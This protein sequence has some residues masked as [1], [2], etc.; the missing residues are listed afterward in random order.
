V[1]GIHF[2]S[3]GSVGRLKDR[4]WRA[5]YVLL[6]AGDGQVHTEVIRVGYDLEPAVDG[7]LRGD[8]PDEF[9]GQGARRVIG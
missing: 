3:I 6:D 9:A 2:V 1:D 7:I 5:G 4:D 8:L